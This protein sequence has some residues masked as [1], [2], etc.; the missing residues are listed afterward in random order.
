MAIVIG[1]T[2]YTVNNSTN[3]VDEWTCAGFFPT[4]KKSC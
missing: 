3:S 1:A 4:K 2:V